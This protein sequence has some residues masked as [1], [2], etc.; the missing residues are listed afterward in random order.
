MSPVFSLPGAFLKVKQMKH[1]DRLI[2]KAKKVCGTT[3]LRFSL[4]MVYPVDGGKWEAYGQLWNYIPR[5]EP[6]SELTLA[7]CICNSVDDAVEAL[8]ELSKKHPND[9]DVTIIID[10]MLEGD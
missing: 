6:G 10:D 3:E 5:N 8:E 1:L 9:R 7:K 2:V 4:G